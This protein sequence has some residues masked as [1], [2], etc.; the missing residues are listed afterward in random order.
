[1]GKRP[2]TDRLSLM[3]RY[4]WSKAR[5]H[6]LIFGAAGNV[7]TFFALV[8]TVLGFFNR[9]IAQALSERWEGI[10]ATWGLLPVVVLVL[11]G[12]MRA[13]WIENQTLR[14]ELAKHPLDGA[15]R[16][17]F[18]S[19]AAP[20]GHGE[21]MFWLKFL[22]ARDV[23]AVRCI[24][25]DPAGVSFSSEW[26]T[27]GAFTPGTG[28]ALAFPREFPPAT[29]APPGDYKVL[30]QAR[31]RFSSAEVDVRQGTYHIP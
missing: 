27:G 18:D 24:V 1:M 11:W 17:G 16:P 14:D 22:D 13:A 25:E 28:E 8:F 19:W 10:E 23:A 12:M 3:L 29:E 20:T 9:P 15:G 2:D 21:I 4:Y 5:E 31:G 7:S 30:W 6:R 26:I